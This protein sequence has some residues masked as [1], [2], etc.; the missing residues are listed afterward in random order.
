MKSVLPAAALAAILPFAAGCVVV[1]SQGHIEREE[2]RFR[3]SGTPEVRLTTFDGAIEIRSG[4]TTAVLVEIEKRGPTKEALEQLTVDTKQDGNRIEVSVKR[5]A[6]EIVVFGIGR[7]SP[8]AKL[9]VTMPRD[10]NVYARSGDG[11]IR[12]DR[13]RGRLELRTGDG[14]IRASD[15]GGQIVLATGDGSVTID[16]A[17]GDLDVDT[18]DGSV[19]VA[20]KLDVV[21]VHTGDGSITFRA[22]P[23]TAMK[24]DWS[25]TTGDGGV[26]LYL[27][28]DFAA[29][30]DAHTGDGAIRNELQIET[31][32]G[33]SE[34]VRRTLKGRLGAGGRTLRI[35]TGDGSVRLKSS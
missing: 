35:R 28:S 15:I 19:S 33:G 10:A 27:P 1:D 18:G 2:K 26:A 11:S 9:I 5:P 13:V 3:V 8:T 22:E 30:L 14:S 23:G 17:E 12:V 31:G 25:M 7:M 21:K 29:E 32:G 20:G 24:A 16:N 4:D 6:G 34:R